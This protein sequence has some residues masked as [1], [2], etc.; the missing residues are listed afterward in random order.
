MAKTAAAAGNGDGESGT[1]GDADIYDSRNTICKNS[2]IRAIYY[3]L[4]SIIT[5]D[6][7]HDATGNW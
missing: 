7:T 4:I 2:S 3:L 1:A 6:H 5:S